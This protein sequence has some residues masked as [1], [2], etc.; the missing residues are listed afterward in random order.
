MLMMSMYQYDMFQAYA[1]Q[2]GL[3]NMAICR[4]CTLLYYASIP[5]QCL[6]C[7]IKYP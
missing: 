7:K 3:F 5:E 1:Y 2:L 4:S 6:K